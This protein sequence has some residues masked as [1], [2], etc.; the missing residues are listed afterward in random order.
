MLFAI[1]AVDRKGALD[2]RLSNY[3]AHKGFLSDTT[4]YGV[5]IVMSGPLTS[6]D[7]R[8]MI[9]SLFLV[10]APNRAAVEEFHRADPFFAAQIWETV[11]ITGFI[12]RQG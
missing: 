3:D 6:D 10:E 1:H 12:R 5:Q 11:T 7:G 4:P 2:K 9:G 8:S